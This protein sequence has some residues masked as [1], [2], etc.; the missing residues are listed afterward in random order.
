MSV[1]KA[2]QGRIG[3]IRTGQIWRRK[4]DGI[5]VKLLDV[6]RVP[7]GFAVMGEEVRY[8]PIAGGRSR[9]ILRQTLF[10]RFEFQSGAADV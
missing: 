10:R 8:R 5:E 1:G 2:D 6:R 7:I 3:P 9:S 4:K